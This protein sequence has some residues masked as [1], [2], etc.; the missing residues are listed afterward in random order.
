MVTTRCRE[1]VGRRAELGTLT[2]FLDRSERVSGVT[3]L[4][5][6]PG[7]GKSRLATEL[8]EIAS[9]RG[10]TV[11]AGRAAQ[12]SNPVPLRPIVDALTGIARSTPIPDDPALAQ[13]RPALASLV[14]NWSG[15]AERE[16]EISPLIL[17]EALLRLLTAL[18]GQGTLL[19]L[20]DL[21]FAD[22]ETLAIVEYLADNL[23][24]GRARCVATVREGEPSAA[25]E[26][27]RATH[28]RR[29]STVVELRRLSDAEVGLMAAACLDQASVPGPVLA[30]LVADCDGLPFA[31]EEILA[32]AVSSGELVN[33]ESGW[34][35]NRSVRTGVPTSIAESVR[36]RIAELGRE[37]ADVVVAAAVLGRQFDWTLL[38]A[39]TGA[40]EPTVLAALSRA[41]DLQLI[42][43][44]CSS[45]VVFRFRHSLTRSAI[46]SSLPPPELAGLSAR[47]AAVISQSYPRLP[48]PVCELV[49]E[50]HETADEP[51]QAAGLLL[52]AGRRALRHGAITSAGRSL[53]RASAMVDQLPLVDLKLRVAIDDALT[54]VHV[55]AGDCDRLAVVAQRLL[56]E[57]DA[58]GATPKL[59]AVTRLRIAR[60]LSE[61]DRL[62]GAE[63]QVAAARRLA[64]RSPD[65]ALGGWMDAV[66]ARC[67]IDAGELD[68][69]LDLARRGLAAAEASGLTGWAAEAACDALEIIGRG[70]RARDT[71]AAR[72]ALERAL[73]IASSKRFPVRQI[74]AMHEL[75]TIEM[76]EDGG[77][78]RLCEARHLAVQ[79][80][81][82]SVATVIDLQ[83]ACAWSLGADLKR[84]AEAAERC[85]QAARRLKMR[86]VEAMALGVLATMVAT[87][88]ERTGAE[89]LAERA[90]RLVPGDPGVL[91]A[92]WGETRVT[93]AIFG[94][95]LVRAVEASDRGIGCA[96]A[97]PLTAPSMAWGYWSL[98]QTI[99]GDRGPEAVAE[100]KGAGAEV[101]FW[102]RGC[103]AYAQA[104][105][106][107][108]DGQRDLAAEL[109]ERGRRYFSR[110][111]PVWNHV[112]HRLVAADAFGA[113]WGEPARWL[114]DAICDFDAA[115]LDRLAS[116][117]RCL[118]RQAGERVPRSGRGTA[119]VPRQL[120]NLGITTREM[121]VFLLLAEGISNADI[122]KRLFISP[123]TVETH[124]G[125]LVAKTGQHGRRGLVA[126]AARFAPA[127]PAEAVAP[128]GNGTP[129]RK[130]NSVSSCCCP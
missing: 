94:N 65:P 34:S 54:T 119:R 73:Q 99:S 90:E 39:L 89:S 122:A 14:P 42:E 82:I 124:I 50:L 80:G 88:K 30:R 91:T 56:A 47:A 67:A 28:S 61:G 116:A 64:E 19:V 52:E 53:A 81:A 105:L 117:C 96:R 112:L 76:L 13:Y 4:L 15:S 123:K 37:V 41:C 71:D 109:A 38:P 74:R 31:V 43:P 70:E 49:A 36:R 22:P 32:A 86:R 25:M 69:A 115:G 128:Q 20:E 106:A 120:R 95:N 100:A 12:A 83:L 10:F 103:L 129:T 7:V 87:S 59:K 98:L 2:A 18:S 1:L 24:E 104:V 8:A 113:G 84:A 126:H 17:G 33:G 101:A 93:A 55:L 130:C 57:L 63:Q 11:L 60:S 114:R 9:A 85:Q 92:T 108:R 110:T 121:D 72:A 27:V 26:I 75:G 79:S 78:R 51:A 44:Q 62:A 97:E 45:Q 46:V 16:T 40:S 66:A 23:S 3:F 127:E 111:A 107:G 6:E 118:L 102:N 5:G 58:V 35:V 48:G 21:Q 77:S 125:R 29:T 68:R